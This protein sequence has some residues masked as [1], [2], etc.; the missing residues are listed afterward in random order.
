MDLSFCSFAVE[1]V[2]KYSDLTSL[3]ESQVI[4]VRT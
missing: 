2:T 1:C 3:P 4:P